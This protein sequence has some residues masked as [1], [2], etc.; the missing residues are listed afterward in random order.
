MLNMVSKSSL[1]ESGKLPRV[2]SGVSRNLTELEKRISKFI[3]STERAP[4][5]EEEVK[6]K[7]EKTSEKEEKVEEQNDPTFKRLKL[8]QL[9]DDIERYLQQSNEEDQ[10]KVDLPFNPDEVQK[11]FRH[12]RA[13]MGSSV[14]ILGQS[15]DSNSAGA[16]NAD[17][18]VDK[19]QEV[20]KVGMICERS[21]FV[22]DSQANT[23]YG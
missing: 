4:A 6:V 5:R 1:S 13:H 8:E 18:L 17:D 16:L 22:D 11:Q 2:S 19:N 15:A 14:V 9:Q 10:V 21:S 12:H 3:S 7:V 20:L 23:T